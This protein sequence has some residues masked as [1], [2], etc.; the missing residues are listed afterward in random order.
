MDKEEQIKK[1]AENLKNSGC[2]ASIEDAI[3]TASR[4]LGFDDALLKNPLMN[5]ELSKFHGQNL[6]TCEVEKAK[7]EQPP[8]Q[9][10]AQP[11][12]MKSAR[13][14]SQE[15]STQRAIESMGMPNLQKSMMMDEINNGLRNNPQPVEQPVREQPIQQQNVDN[16]MPQNN[17]QQPMQQPV[18]QQENSF[19][20]QPSI[21]PFPAETPQA[22]IPS[23]EAQ[24]PV[25]A[26]SQENTVDEFSMFEQIPEMN[27]SDF[28]QNN[29]QPQAQPV[30]I[31]DPFTNTQPTWQAAP[32]ED[33]FSS[34]Q[35]VQQHPAQ[36]MQQPQ[37]FQQPQQMQQQMQQQ[38]MQQPVEQMQ[39]QQ[40][41]QTQQ[42]VEQIQTQQFQQTQQAAS[43]QEQSAEDSIDLVEMFNFAKR[44]RG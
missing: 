18:Q 39:T 8:M 42:P 12:P 11:Q 13:E 25:Q 41:Q 30:Q 16:H 17:I 34:S 23:T 5:Q 43:V 26:Q 37:Q 40:F 4:M 44:N 28:T 10:Q 24:A 6:V 27:E 9:N 31:E 1:L 19:F 14:M 35:P 21:N 7:V 33:F 38:P 2:C 3:R 32:E 22:Q 20:T 15:M 29:P 36:P